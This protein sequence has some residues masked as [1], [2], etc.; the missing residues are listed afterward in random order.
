LGIKGHHG[1]KQLIE[2]GNLVVQRGDALGCWLPC[3]QYV[4]TFICNQI[5]L[6]FQ[7]I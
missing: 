5:F 4:R 1:D 3:S 7:Y 2:L 6:M